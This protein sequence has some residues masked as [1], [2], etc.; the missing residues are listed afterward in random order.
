MSDIKFADIAWGATFQL[1]MVRLVSASL[2]V[3]LIST[4]SDPTSFIG[5]LFG[6]PIFLGI[7]VLLALAGSYLAKST[8]VE[9]FGFL[10]LPA[11]LVVIAGD[12]PLWVLS[13]SKPDFLPV[14]R[15]GFFNKIVLFVMK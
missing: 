4:V 5:A 10:C 13:K 11:F 1:A 12:P 15:F 14:D 8:G 2:V 6:A 9:L 3:I 7:L